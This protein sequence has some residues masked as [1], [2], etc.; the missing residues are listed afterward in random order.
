MGTFKEREKK[1][2]SRLKIFKYILKLLYNLSLG[3][4]LI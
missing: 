2:Q 4:L 3:L 1:S